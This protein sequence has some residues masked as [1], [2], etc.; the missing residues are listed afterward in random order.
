MSE[1]GEGSLVPSTSAQPSKTERERRERRERAM[2]EA[3]LT[4]AEIGK[5]IGLLV[6]AGLRG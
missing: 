6:P 1:M 5:P 2:A 3:A 4:L